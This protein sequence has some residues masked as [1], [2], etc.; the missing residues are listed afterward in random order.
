MTDDDRVIYDRMSEREQRCID[1]LSEGSKH[2]A[3]LTWARMNSR[4]TRQPPPGYVPW[5]KRPASRALVDREP[6]DDLDE[7]ERRFP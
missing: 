2:G 6:G 7:S 1:A 3:I 5:D 4:P